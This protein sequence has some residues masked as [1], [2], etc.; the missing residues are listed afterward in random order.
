ME[1]TNTGA[2]APA[3]RPTFLT[4]LC[5]LSF[6]GVAFSLIGGIMNYFTYSALSSA[7]DAFSGMGTE[8]QQMGD[9]VNAMSSMLGLDPAKMATSALIQALLNIPIL[10]GVLMMWKQKKT[11]FYIYTAFEVIQPLLPLFMG[12]GLM[13]GMMAILGLIFAIIF[14]VLYGLNLKHMS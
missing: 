7:G 14:I 5:I 11:G 6:V 8:G 3:K 9:A 10:I 4:V 12:L 1:Q 2:A 13:G